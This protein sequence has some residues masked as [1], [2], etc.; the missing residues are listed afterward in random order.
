MDL[1]GLIVGLGNPGQRY[2][3]TRHNLGFLVVDQ[4]LEELARVQS[5]PCAALK[6]KGAACDIFRCRPPGA[7]GEWL[8]AKP[9]TF[10]NLSGTA[11][12]PVSHFYRLPPER[13]VVVHDELDLPLGRL[14]LKVGGGTAGH[15]GLDSLVA[16]LGSRDFVRLRLGIGKPERGET[17]DHVLRPF[18]REEVP[19]VE[20]VIRAG[21]DGVLR[22][23][24]EGFEPARRVVNALCLESEAKSV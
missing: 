6:V 13:I 9:L 2:H 20:A 1:A 12:A 18:S 15:K 21:A 23:V 8:L 4:L 22:Y 11:V 5:T 24:A 14:R 10:M 16:C 17:V 3:F 19:L 7:S